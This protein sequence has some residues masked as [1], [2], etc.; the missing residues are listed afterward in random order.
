MVEVESFLG[1][2]AGS[3]VTIS[4]VPQLITILYNKDSKNVSIF[5]YIILLVARILWTTYGL[6][7]PDLQIGITNCISGFLTVL[8]IISAI[9]YR[10]KETDNKDVKV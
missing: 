9:Y 1:Y 10:K 5:T 7:K 6:R 8:I 2:I 4:L 3:L